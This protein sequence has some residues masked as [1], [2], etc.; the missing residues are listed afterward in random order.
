MNSLPRPTQEG[1]STV[2]DW[3]MRVVCSW[4]CRPSHSRPIRQ[5]SFAKV[6]PELNPGKTRQR[7]GPFEIL[8]R[9]VHLPRAE[10]ESITV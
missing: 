2:L 6:S 8:C 5:T 10:S 7:P 3:D 9:Y 4:P 1:L